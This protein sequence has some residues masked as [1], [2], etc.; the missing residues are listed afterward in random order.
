MHSIVTESRITVPSG[1]SFKICLNG[2]HSKTRIGKHMA[3]IYPVKNLM[4]R[5]DALSSLFT[6]LTF[7]L[8]FKVQAKQGRIATEWDTKDSILRR[9]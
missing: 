8:L 7:V 6:T 4:E 3:D 9:C 1:R 5:R 2:S